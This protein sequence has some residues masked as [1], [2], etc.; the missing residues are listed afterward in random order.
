MHSY[1]DSANFSAYFCEKKSIKKKEF[2]HKVNYHI[3][4]V[5]FTFFIRFWCNERNYAVKPDKLGTLLEMWD[6]R[7]NSGCTIEWDELTNETEKIIELHKPT[8]NSAIEIN[9]LRK[10][11]YLNILPCNELFQFLAY[12]VINKITM[13]Y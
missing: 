1:N 2:L 7:Q 5:R 8:T 13:I 10:N 11:R 3:K 4:Q 9:N 6:D 12:L